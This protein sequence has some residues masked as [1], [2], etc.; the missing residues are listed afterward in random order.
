MADNLGR[1]GIA[2]DFK[3]RGALEAK[4]CTVFGAERWSLVANDFT[5]EA[6]G[7]EP[8]AKLVLY[9]VTASVGGNNVS[10]HVGTWAKGKRKGW[11]FTSAYQLL[12][13]PA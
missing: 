8:S 9:Y 1:S 4:L 3:T 13:T 2:H 7:Q 12:R 6:Y 5:E 10:T 11:M